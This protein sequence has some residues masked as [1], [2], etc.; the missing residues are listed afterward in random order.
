MAPRKTPK[1]WIRN[2]ADQIA[3]DKFGCK[4]DP[5][6]GQ[7]ICDFIEDHLR[8]YEGH[9]MGE[10]FTLQEWQRDALMRIFSWV[11]YHPTFKKW[12]RRFRKAAIFVS[13][14]NGKSP[15]AAA[16]G[17]YLTIP[18]G[19]RDEE[20]KTFTAAKDGKQAKII[21]KHAMRMCQLSPALE[22]RTKIN[23]H[24]GIITD[25]FT[26]SEYKL[27]AGDNISGQEGLNGSCII[28]EAH[29]VPHRLG[30]TLEYMGASRA[31][32]LQFMV[33]TAGDDPD[34]WGK[35]QWD[36]G[37]NV[38][39]GAVTD[40]QY[41]HLHYGVPNDIPDRRCLTD[42][43]L[44]MANP[45]WGVTIDPEEIREAAKRAKNEGP[46]AWSV[47]KKYRLNQWQRTETPWLSLARWQE[48]EKQ[49]NLED[50]AGREVAIGCDLASV[51][52]FATLV[53]T[54]DEGD[55]QYLQIPYTWVAQT[56]ASDN[57]HVVDFQAMIEKGDLYEAPGE[58]IDEQL[59][60]DKLEELN[61]LFE[62]KCLA[63]DPYK[64]RNLKIWC[65]EELGWDAESNGIL[66]EFA[67]RITTFATPTGEFERLVIGRKLL[68]VPN[69]CYDWQIGHAHVKED[70][71]NNKRPVKP[72]S[73]EIK[74]IDTVV[75]GI[76]SLWGAQA[77]I[78]PEPVLDYY[79]T[80]P[81]EV[82]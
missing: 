4:W 43:Y 57:Q 20:K 29:V 73:K 64:S 44:K 69:S 40:Y 19:R 33:S 79:E 13:K 80:N 76:M 10:P 53:V 70:T 54:I 68:H 25:T 26:G 39:R 31:E 60:Y 75:A 56:Y 9:W 71:N 8:L 21:Q 5:S 16:V 36:Y 23:E 2:E 62:V 50:Y 17:L 49:I 63:F 14:K 27:I 61:E 52:D 7:H 32:A 45:S 58:Q 34:S 24:F 35:R 3:V 15:L 78:D 59:I 28:D 11:R 77:A 72:D 74:K 18:D 65:E 48:A 46:R 30:E 81:L 42:K 22:A 6:R 12:V 1:K 37:E 51:R 82:G 55:G 38:N 47:F 67:Q 66:V 41:F